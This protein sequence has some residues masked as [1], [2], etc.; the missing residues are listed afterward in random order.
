MG[1]GSRT[2]NLCSYMITKRSNRY[3]KLK[4]G[5]CYV[6]YCNLLLRTTCKSQKCWRGEK[7][8]GKI[9]IVN[10]YKLIPITHTHQWMN[11]LKKCCQMFS[12][13]LQRCLQLKNRT[14]ITC[15]LGQ[16]S[17]ITESLW[18]QQELSAPERF[19]S[20]TQSFYPIVIQ[21]QL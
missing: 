5:I 2:S 14:S 9:F 10:K 8:F 12:S 15:L 7:A 3:Q 19:L 6:L 11:P 13:T 21:S 16:N 20:E 18:L 17:Q 1:F 4:L